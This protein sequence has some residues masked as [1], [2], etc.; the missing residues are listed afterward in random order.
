MRLSDT[1]VLVK[2]K[3]RTRR[4]RLFFGIVILAVLFSAVIV[5]LVA[6]ANAR[7]SLNQ[8]VA[9]GLNGRFLVNASNSKPNPLNG[10]TPQELIDI[11]ERLYREK[12]EKEEAVYKTFGLTYVENESDSPIETGKGKKRVRVAT[13]I[14]RKAV[15]EYMRRFQEYDDKDATELSDE[16]QPVNLFRVSSAYALNGSLYGLVDGE[17]DLDAIGSESPRT[18]DTYFNNFLITDDS[19]V[20]SFSVNGATLNEGEIPVMVTYRMAEELMGLDRLENASDRE[21]YERHTYIR[22]HVNSSSYGFCYRNTAS[23]ANILEAK[24]ANENSYA[25]VKYRM[26]S[27]NCGLASVETDGRNEEEKRNADLLKAIERE[28]GDYV[29]PKQ[30]MI[31]MRVVG[32]LPDPRE[33]SVESSMFELFKKLVSTG[34]PV[35]VPYIPR[36]LLEQNV[37][38]EAFSNVIGYSE[39]HMYSLL[40][41]DSYVLEF[42]SS[43]DA[44]AF[45]REKNCES[46]VCPKETPFKL[47]LYGN[48]SVLVDQAFAGFFSVAYWAALI[49]C[50]VGIVLLFNTVNRVISDSQR[51]IA[52]YRAIGYSKRDIGKI[53]FLYSIVYVGLVYL[54]VVII[55]LGGPWVLN[56]LFADR[57]SVFLT[58]FFDT[59]S[60]LGFNFANVGPSSYNCME[61]I[62]TP[63]LIPHPIAIKKVW[64]SGLSGRY[65]WVDLIFPFFTS[66][67]G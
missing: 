67:T 54:P 50:I 12:L 45:I 20:E 57:L 21:I 26:P 19:L 6:L 55:G 65:P 2:T 9:S 43:E 13:E 60:N 47:I 24:S 32:V 52:V 33:I 17:D 28:L 29:E 15:V 14:G 59:K 11:A 40:S 42:S 34:L 31:V 25:K 5:S 49:V 22:E 56:V 4:V 1:L 48:N 35:D 8:Y 36:S 41:E 58:V 27:S 66:L 10:E 53:Y 3:F 30:E 62:S 23:Q 18:I 51:E 16:F 7:G 37:E 46:A 38:Q 64:Y 44:Q 39:E 63:A 61:S